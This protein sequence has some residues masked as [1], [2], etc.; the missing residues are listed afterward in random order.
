V[1]G[2]HEA[3]WFE[4]KAVASQ[5]EKPQRRQRQRPGG[6][7]GSATNQPR[8][9]KEHQGQMSKEKP[10]EQGEK[11]EEPQVGAERHERRERG[12]SAAFNQRDEQH[13]TRKGAASDRRRT[14][15]I[16]EADQGV[17]QQ[18]VHDEWMVAGRGARPRGFIGTRMEPPRVFWLPS[19]GLR[20]GTMLRPRGGE[21]LA[22]E[23]Q[24]LRDAGVTTLVSCLEGH[25]AAE[26]GLEDEAALWRSIGGRFEQFPIK[27]R[28]L[29]A[30]S[31]EMR[32][33]ATRLHTESHVGAVAVHCRAGIGRSTMVVAAVLAAAGTTTDEALAMIET[34]RGRPVPDTADQVKWLRAY[35]AWQALVGTTLF[36]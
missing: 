20:I 24:A 19:A 18:G 15:Q 14:E 12:C 23:L 8:S 21:W 13:R 5:E 22:A 32:E 10:G 9:N 26:L 27:D 11:T 28:G 36:R 17:E 30:S 1:L 3:S 16:E 31:A 6:G 2:D 33:L 7:W 35:E 4:P 29:P 25:E 34:A